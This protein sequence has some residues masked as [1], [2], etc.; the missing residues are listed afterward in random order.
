MVG[1]LKEQVD[2]Q[3]ILHEAPSQMDLVND[4]PFSVLHRP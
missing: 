3:I 2:S 1:R 4:G